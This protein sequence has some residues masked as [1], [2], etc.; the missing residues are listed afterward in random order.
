MAI[1]IAFIVWQ[2]W[3]TGLDRLVILAVVSPFAALI[4][5]IMAWGIP[6]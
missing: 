5:L 1:V 4:Q 6:T 2:G 3:T